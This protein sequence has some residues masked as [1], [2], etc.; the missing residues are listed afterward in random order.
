MSGYHEY[1]KSNNAIEAEQRGLVTA[2]ALAKLAGVKRGATVAEFMCPSEWHHSSSW[3]NKVDYYDPDDLTP[4]LIEKMRA[5]EADALGAR[6]I[7]AHVEFTEWTGSRNHPRATK[8]EGDVELTIKGK[9]GAFALDGRTWRK[10]LDG[11]HFYYREL[12]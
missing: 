7:Q 9:W 1:S 12:H 2:S 8:Y 4:E 11:N 3:Y 10:A 5:F 6:T